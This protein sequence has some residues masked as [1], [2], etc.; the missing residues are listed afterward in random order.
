VVL[1]INSTAARGFAIVGGILSVARFFF[2]LT[3]DLPVTGF[4]QVDFQHPDGF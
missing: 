4:M 2:L 1:N 3:T